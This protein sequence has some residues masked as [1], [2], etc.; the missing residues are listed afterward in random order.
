MTLI[1]L[2]IELKAIIRD[3]S[4]GDSVA[5]VAGPQTV[6]LTD[7]NNL[8]GCLIITSS[9]G[10]V[11][12]ALR[13]HPQLLTRLLI[14]ARLCVQDVKKFCSS[15]K[16]ILQESKVKSK[17]FRIVGVFIVLVTYNIYRV[18]NS[19]GYV[20]VDSSNDIPTDPL[21]PE[22]YAKHMRDKALLCLESGSESSD[23]RPVAN[24]PQTVSSNDSA[25]YYPL[26]AIGYLGYWVFT[27]VPLQPGDAF[28]QGKGELS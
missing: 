13:T 2:G 28:P 14:V 22:L 10:A 25:F 9:M 11:S 7:S 6:V 16:R 26:G 3:S 19:N 18:I 27:N 20:M 21:Y 8:I 15:S 5:E 12:L 24:R 4:E 1:P 17:K 23:S